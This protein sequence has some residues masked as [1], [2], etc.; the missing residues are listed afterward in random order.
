MEGMIIL[1]LLIIIVG[2]SIGKA[3]GSRSGRS[4]SGQPVPGS[5]AG[6]PAPP[7]WE[8]GALPPSLGLRT[9]FGLERLAERLS[10]ALGAGYAE[11]IK[12]RVMREHPGMNDAQWDWTWLELQRYLLMTAVL[13][14]VPMFSEQVDRAWH[15]MLMFT[16]EYQ[17]FCESFTGHLIHHAPEAGAETVPM[18]G[19]RAWFDWMYC[20]LFE[21]TPY[22]SWI[23]GGFFRYPLPPEQLSMLEELSEEELRA[24]LFNSQTPKLLPEVGL[25]IGRIISAAKAQIAEGRRGRDSFNSRPYRQEAGAGDTGSTSPIGQYALLTAPFLMYSLWSNGNASEFEEEMGQMLPEEEQQREKNNSGCSSGTACSGG[26]QEPWHRSEDGGGSGGSDSGGGSDSSG[27]SCGGGSS[28]SSGC[29]GG[30]D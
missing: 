20:Q 5:R 17:R 28:C 9:E 18:P 12:L 4:R 30:G 2:I 23:W 27:S 10:A 11:Q 19:A 21:P 26:E 24:E 15:E 13:R 22:S 3:S 25:S 29:G 14:R 1:I 8:A 16:R 7:V 6:R